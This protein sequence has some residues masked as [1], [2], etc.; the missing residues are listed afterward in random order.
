MADSTLSVGFT[1]DVVRDTSV[2]AKAKT[3]VERAK[4]EAGLVA[5]HAVDHSAIT[6]S[7][8]A[9]V[10]LAGLAVGYLLGSRASHRHWY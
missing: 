9:I 2:K 6:G 5:A 4:D 8:L 1:G 10:G 3:A 7:A